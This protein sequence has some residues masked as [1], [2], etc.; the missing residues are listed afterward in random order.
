MVGI[1]F[2][3][4]MTVAIGSLLDC[5]I[6]GLNH[7]DSSNKDHNSINFTRDEHEH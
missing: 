3:F 1:V 7:Q 4:I 5:F 2:S 6:D